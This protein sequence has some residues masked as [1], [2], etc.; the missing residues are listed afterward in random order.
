MYFLWYSLCLFYDHMTNNTI[1]LLFLPLF[2]FSSL[3]FFFYPCMIKNNR[4]QNDNSFQRC[5]VNNN[6]ALRYRI[7]F[8]SVPLLIQ[9]IFRYSGKSF[10]QFIFLPI[11]ESLFINKMRLIEILYVLSF[12]NCLG[13]TLADVIPEPSALMRKIR[14]I[15]R[16][17]SINTKFNPDVILSTV[18]VLFNLLKRGLKSSLFQLIKPLQYYQK[19][20]P[21]LSNDIVAL[22]LEI[23]I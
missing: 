18:S 5:R 21:N 17:K 10:V 13:G 6:C 12:C 20:I 3:S 15:T 4:K 14:W 22:L 9:C 11:V 23:K 16:G 8:S 2:F 7:L 1:L 19:M